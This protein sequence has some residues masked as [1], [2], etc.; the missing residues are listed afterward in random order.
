MPM[1]EN[2]PQ[3]QIGLG[4]K[5]GSY[6]LRALLG[7]GR[8]TE[9]YRAYSPELKRDVALKIYHPDLK[10]F[11]SAQFK[12]EMGTIAALK[13]PNIMRIYDFGIEGELY[14][15]VM[16]KIKGTGLRDMLSAHPTGLERDETLRIFSQLASAVS[17][18]HDHNVVH[19][20]LKPDNVLLDQSQRPVLTD[21]NIPCLRERGDAFRSSTPAYLAPE[22][23]TDGIA[24]P[25]SDIYTLGILLYE[26]VT[27]DVPFKGSTYEQIVSQHLSTPPRLPSQIT[28]GLDPRIE[29]AILKA[30]SKDPAERYP[31]ARDML[32]VMETEESEDR[33]QTVS[34]TREQVQKRRSEIRRFQ[35][36]RL[37][38]PLEEQRSS[39][40]SG[41]LPL[42]VVGIVLLILVVILIVWFVL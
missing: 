18:A 5:L 23:I 8:D 1:S 7:R 3:P 10:R 34:L 33:F 19:G 14:Y 12:K 35:Q 21:F 2:K 9:V 31:S 6:T 15:I 17:C 42:A 37:D 4:S 28:I 40:L 22:Q 13:H 36:S 16:E 41:K 39:A 32:S 29:R 24:Q 27:G 30:L 20:N 26:M 25:Q 38:E 11:T